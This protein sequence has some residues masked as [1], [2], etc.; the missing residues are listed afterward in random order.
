MTA[1]RS[2]SAWSDAS[3]SSASANGN[4]DTRGWIVE[5]NYLPWL[6]TKITLQYTAY[7]Q[8]NGGSS[9]YDGFGRNASANGTTYLLAWLNF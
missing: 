5:A 2:A 3:P 7:T 6:N 8:F 9:N 1:T 4:P